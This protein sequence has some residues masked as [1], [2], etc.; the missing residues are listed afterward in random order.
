MHELGIVFHIAD[1]V[2]KIAAENDVSHVKKVVLQIGEV[3]AILHEYLQDCWKW[4]AKRMPLFDGC[5]LEIE[6]IPAVTYCEECSG[7]YETVTFGKI[8]PY[9]QSERTYLLQGNEAQIK[10]IVVEEE[11]PSTP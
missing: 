7:Q 10:E 4:N 8:C 3:S 6:T 5:E 11:A 2:E 9:C 1:S